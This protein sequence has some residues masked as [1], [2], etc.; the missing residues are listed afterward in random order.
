MH[1]ENLSAFC[2]HCGIKTSK[3]RWWDHLDTHH[4]FSSWHC[5]YTTGV[6]S[7]WQPLDL[8][9]WSAGAVDRQPNR[10]LLWTWHSQ[11]SFCKGEKIQ[12]L[13]TLKVGLDSNVKL[14]QKTDVRARCLVPFFSHLLATF[15]WLASPEK[16]ANPIRHTEACRHGEPLAQ[17]TH[18][19][20]H[21][22]MGRGQGALSQSCLHS[23]LPGFRLTILIPWFPKGTPTAIQTL[24]NEDDSSCW[25]WG[26]SYTKPS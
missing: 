22:I 10:W 8:V 13:P 1:L 16:P 6:P 26:R 19:S 2:Q 3:R 14:A 17:V 15:S 18:L 5:H 7:S 4:P 20:W 24:T 11:P 23:E 12:S 9:V 25:S 21:S